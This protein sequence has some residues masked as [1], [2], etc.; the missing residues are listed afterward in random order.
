MLKAIPLTRKQAN[1]FVE[2]MHR[3]HKPSQGDKFRVGAML[4]GVLV[5]VAQ[6]GHPLAR[7]L[8]DGKTVEVIRLCTD[9]TKNV[10]TFL[11]SRCA[12]AAQE[13]GYK[14]IITYILES[15]SGVSLR[16]A[17]WHLEN[18]SCGGGSWGL[19]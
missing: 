12:R 1:E 19:P 3:H 18:P 2:K 5:G 16:A 13:L 8:C 15:E 17:G 14:K 9:G 7:H 11:Y 4:D 6:V 10:C